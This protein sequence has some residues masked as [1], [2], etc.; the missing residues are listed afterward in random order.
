MRKRCFVPLLWVVV[1]PSLMAGPPAAAV[2][3]FDDYVSGVESRLA[4]QHLTENGFL[5][6]AMPWRRGDD[7]PIDRLTPR[8]HAELS[9]AL[10]HHWRG[11]AFAPGA[12]AADFERLLRDFNSY[13]QTFAPQVLQSRV[14]IENAGRLQASIRVRQKHVVTVVL[15]STCD[16]TFGRLDARHGFSISRSTR[17]SEID[18]PGTP[19]EHALASGEEH[20]FLWRLNTYWSYEERN[21]GLYLQIETVSL[22]RSIP[23]G[24]GW[25]IRP[26]VVSI[27]RESLEFTLRAASAALQKSSESRLQTAQE[28]SPH[29]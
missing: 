18:S 9:G 2:T 16:V 12:R 5:A 19:A 29:E 6:E 8:P 26:Y 27:P 28:K 1:L 25:V 11:T 15:D 13:P 7:I 4:H 24:L 21:G 20:G 23:L 22:T 17:I 3:A 10:L 14:S